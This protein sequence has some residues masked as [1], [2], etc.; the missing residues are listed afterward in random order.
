MGDYGPRWSVEEQ[1]MIDLM[2]LAGCAVIPNINREHTDI[3][4]YQSGVETRRFRADTEY[5]AIRKCFAYW[6]KSYAQTI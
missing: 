5:E 2:A 6:E 3:Y 1:T 4:F